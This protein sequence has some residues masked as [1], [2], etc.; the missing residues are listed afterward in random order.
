M[1]LDNHAA[2]IRCS[3]C[4]KFISII[5]FHDD[6]SINYAII[7]YSGGTRSSIQNVN[8]TYPFVYKL[9]TYTL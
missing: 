1:V 7:I 2:F 8:I 3:R 5:A 4:L 6:Y 9:I